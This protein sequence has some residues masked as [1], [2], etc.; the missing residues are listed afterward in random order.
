MK[1]VSVLFLAT[2]AL[3]HGTK[4][5][6][7]NDGTK[8]QNLNDGTKAQNLNDTEI[9]SAIPEGRAFLY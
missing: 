7:L 4:A 3:L 9:I 1:L 5:Q 8:A 2:V 6:N